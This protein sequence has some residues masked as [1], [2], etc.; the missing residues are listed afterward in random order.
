[1]RNVNSTKGVLP[2]Q[3]E[4]PVHKSLMPAALS[5]RGG[6]IISYSRRLQML[7][8]SL[9]MAGVTA[10]DAGAAGGV[11]L[12]PV[13]SLPIQIT[14]ELRRGPETT[15]SAV[16]IGSEPYFRAFVTAVTEHVAARLAR[17]K[18]CIDSAESK[19]RSL[20]QFVNW[21]LTTS[22]NQ[23]LAS[24][25]SLDAPSAD[26]CRISSPWID[27]VVERRPVPLVR[28]VFRWNKRQFLADQA[29]LAGARNVPPGV[30][31]PLKASEYGHFAQEYE[32]SGLFHVS[33]IRRKQAD[34]RNEARIPPDL[35]WLFRKSW[36]STRGGPFSG[37]M[38]S[39]VQKSAEHYTQLVIAVIDRCFASDDAAIHYNS[40]LDVA[41]LISL[42]QYKITTLT[43]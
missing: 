15:L 17:D 30:A 6:E 1:M 29:V 23:A 39:A 4:P 14:N 9:L 35:L 19:K 36:Q 20:L 10:G 42:D 12:C 40:I 7:H 26:G 18:L 27:F 22:E 13:D 3:H 41:D 24:L 31:M 33:E 37:D 43:R 16:D 32:N 11:S 38:D 5:Q 2:V 21:P 8:F 28:G 25:P 34:E